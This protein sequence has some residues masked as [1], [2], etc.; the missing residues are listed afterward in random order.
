[1]KERSDGFVVLRETATDMVCMRL[2]NLKVVEHFWPLVNTMFTSFTSALT[3]L[4]IALI[5]AS[6]ESSLPLIRIRKM[7]MGV[8]FFLYYIMVIT[9]WRIV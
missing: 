1:M 5:Q 2:V 9:L 3:S 6:S 8:S 4:S 7:E